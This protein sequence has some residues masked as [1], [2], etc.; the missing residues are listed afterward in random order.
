MPYR[1]RRKRLRRLLAD[2]RPPL[3]LMPA[4]RELVAA[5]AWIHDHTAA[6]VEGVV[7]K[8]REHGY[9]PRQRSWKVRTRVTADA[10]VG[11]VIG[12]LDSP[13]APARPTG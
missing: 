8:H 10:V 9:R 2:A 5:Q 4:T 1:K 13:E 3:M 12:A 6:G 7:V 11:G